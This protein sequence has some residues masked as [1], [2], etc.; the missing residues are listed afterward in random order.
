MTFNNLEIRESANNLP[1]ST[2]YIYDG[3]NI[4]VIHDG[5][6]R[7]IYIK[8]INTAVEFIEPNT[9][10]TNNSTAF[11]IGSNRS[12]LY[13]LNPTTR[14]LRAIGT[15]GVSINE[16]FY[17]IN[18]FNKL[19]DLRYGTT[20]N[21]FVPTCGHIKD[22]TIVLGGYMESVQ[23]GISI[24]NRA[25]ANE[26]AAYMYSVDN[27]ATFIGPI[28]PFINPINN[29]F[30]T[31]RV[32]NTLFI[33]DNW[34]FYVSF[35]LGASQGTNLNFVQTLGVDSIGNNIF[36]PFLETPS[37]SASNLSLP[38]VYFDNKIYFQSSN[39]TGY[40][41]YTYETDTSNFVTLENIT[42]FSIVPGELRITT[43]D[44]CDP[45]IIPALNE[46][47]AVTITSFKL[48]GTDFKINIGIGKTYVEETFENDEAFV[49]TNNT[50]SLNTSHFLQP[51]SLNINLDQ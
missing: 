37:A 22:S 32:I 47:G 41:V 26:T 45:V 3:S 31:G 27:G 9:T 51:A 6:K 29:T 24:D 36:D 21:D 2:W 17:N 12:N 33:N 15:D 50:D 7:Y 28:F 23:P 5:T 35:N 18:D 14:Q 13:F 30:Y 34:V 49:F 11:I 44:S 19:K 39:K 16:Q 4:A 25:I 48:L 43:L 42:G 1:R 46:Q 40:F 20:G 38:M 8:N 10:Y